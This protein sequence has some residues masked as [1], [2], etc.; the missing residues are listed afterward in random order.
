MQVYRF[1]D[2]GTAKPDQDARKNLPHHLIDIR[3]PSRQFN[4]G[5]FVTLADK[6][7]KE[8]T[9]RGNLPV[10][11]GGTA[12]YFK[13]FLFLIK[14]PRKLLTGKAAWLPGLSSGSWPC[15]VTGLC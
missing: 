3:D 15:P 8:I 10:I 1:Q 13:T 2:I 6:L 7:V 9:G 4:A 12:F 11:A 14:K 5:D